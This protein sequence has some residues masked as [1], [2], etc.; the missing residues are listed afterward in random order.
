MTQPFR[1]DD[2]DLKKYLKPAPTCACI[3]CRIFPYFIYLMLGAGILVLM[4]RVM[5]SQRLLAIGMVSLHT[6]QLVGLTLFFA[7]WLHGKMKK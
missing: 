6:L 4:S 1:V 3:G 7:F 5:G 2:R